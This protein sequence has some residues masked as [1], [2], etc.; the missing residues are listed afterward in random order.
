MIK[1]D[2]ILI[3]NFV[4]DINQSYK[5]MTTS[6]QLKGNILHVAID[7]FSGKISFEPDISLIRMI[8]ELDNQARRLLCDY[9]RD[10][11]VGNDT[12][13]VDNLHSGMFKTV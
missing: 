13:W 1:I 10:D 9:R 12:S 8:L 4:L 5:S 6:N 7:F 2:K 11:T 3:Q